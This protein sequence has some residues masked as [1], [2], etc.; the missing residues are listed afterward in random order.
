MSVRRRQREHVR[1]ESRRS[2]RIRRR[3][4]LGRR[5][6]DCF[7]QA[8]NAIGTSAPSA[9]VDATPADSVPTLTAAATSASQ[10]SLTWTAVAG[11]VNYEIERSVNDSA[12]A[13]LITIP[14]T[15][16]NDSGLTANTTY[17]YKVRAV[18]GTFSNIDPATTIVFT[19]PVLNAGTGVKAT[20]FAELR[21][22][23]NAMRAA[24]GLPAQIFTDPTLS[25]AIRIKAMHLTELRTA[26]DA[27]RLEIGLA[28]L[29]YT[30]PSPSGTTAK[31][32]H[33]NELRGGVN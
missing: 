16:H 32:V 30:D 21:T 13:P 8:I 6:D 29:S 25:T 26:L 17:L 22:A 4:V 33:V 5:A 2:V 14:G 18:A 19:D 10:V 9:T 3:T 15:S 27:A 12:F 11:T 31:A 28:P 24:A 23:V 7:V 20:H 1:A